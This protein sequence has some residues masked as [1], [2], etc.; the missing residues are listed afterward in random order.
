MMYSVNE[1]R[2]LHALDSLRFELKFFLYSESTSS[3]SRLTGAYESSGSGSPCMPS[4][5]SRRRTTARLD[6]SSPSSG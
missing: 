2:L 3:M 1:M 6:R 4:A 5:P